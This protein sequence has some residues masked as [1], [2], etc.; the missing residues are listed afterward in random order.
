MAE[1][2]QSAQHPPG[3]AVAELEA[4]DDDLLKATGCVLQASGKDSAASLLASFP[5]P[6][7]SR[8]PPEKA[9]APLPAM[10]VIYTSAACPS[11]A[12]SSFNTPLAYRGHARHH[13]Q[14]QLS[15]Q[16]CMMSYGLREQMCHPPPRCATYP[17]HGQLLALQCCR[18]LHRFDLL[19]LRCAGVQVA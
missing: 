2:L 8:T 5:G 15:I 9:G 1:Q 19:A 11:N 13:R 12:S 7:S 16:P 18:H 4:Q 6:L 17:M 10:P 14:A 3:R